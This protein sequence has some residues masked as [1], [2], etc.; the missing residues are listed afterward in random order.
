M[1]SVHPQQTVGDRIV[2]RARALRG[3][4][5]KQTADALEVSTETLRKWQRG[6]T[7]PTR[8]R[9]KLICQVLDVSPEWV[10][11]GAEPAIEHAPPSVGVNSE[12]LRS[13][14]FARR[15]EGGVAIALMNAEASMG[16]GR[17]RPEQEDVVTEMAVSER[18]LRTHATFSA[19]ENLALIT[20]FGDSMSPTFND[21]DVL[22]VDRGVTDVKLDAIYVLSLRD[23]L[24]IKRLQRR[25]D[26]GVLMLSD[27]R[28]YEPYQIPEADRGQF[29]VLGRVVMAWNAHRL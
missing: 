9:T 29:Q 1:G 14:S 7:A 25:P 4:S 17:F 26:G 12:T 16:I 20:G 23:E 21:G 13:I 8:N 2:K 11:H 10:Q 19:P 27:N 15:I 6:E 18:W 22:M 24:Y 3:W 5:I 28:A